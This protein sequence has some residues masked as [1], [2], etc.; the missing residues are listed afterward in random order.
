MNKSGR[1][2]VKPI[3]ICPFCCD[4]LRSERLDA[5]LVE[6]LDA[7]LLALQEAEE[8]EEAEQRR[9]GRREAGT[10]GMGD[11]ETSDLLLTEQ[12]EPTSKGKKGDV[13]NA[14]SIASAASPASSPLNTAVGRDKDRANDRSTAHGTIS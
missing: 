1:C 11:D 10:C 2:G 9:A 12:G 13:G 8:R 14:E 4:S 6:K 5:T 7:N 3:A